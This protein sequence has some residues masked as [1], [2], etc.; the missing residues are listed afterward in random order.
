MP[1]SCMKSESIK[2][3]NCAAL[4]TVQ[5]NKVMAFT[6]WLFHGKRCLSQVLRVNGGNS[7]YFL[8]LKFSWWKIWRSVFRAICWNFRYKKK[9]VFV[10]DS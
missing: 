2:Y 9:K 8:K 6:V 10:L 4:K 1:I 5:V 7:T 3:F